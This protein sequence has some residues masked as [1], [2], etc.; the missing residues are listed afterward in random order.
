MPDILADVT[1]SGPNILCYTET[2]LKVST[3]DQFITIPGYTVHRSDRITGRKKSGGGVSIYVKA[4]MGTSMI[5]KTSKPTSHVEH[6][7]VKSKISERH[8]VIIGC[9]YRPPSTTGV[10]V[11]ADF[12]EIEEKI[13]TVISNHA[14]CP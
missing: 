8:S 3:P 11:D 9:I 4:N 6:I 13:Q 12:D 14:G 5:M 2:N 10:Q 7:W 1:S